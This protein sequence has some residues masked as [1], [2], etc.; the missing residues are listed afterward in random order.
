MAIRSANLSALS[1][2]LSSEQNN[3]GDSESFHAGFEVLSWLFAHHTYNYLRPG[4]NVG[5]FNI[6][7]EGFRSREKH[8]PI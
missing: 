2:G 8:P 5:Q 4:L 1:R 6:P 7:A 3:R